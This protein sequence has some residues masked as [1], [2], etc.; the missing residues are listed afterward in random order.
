MY[1]C[2]FERLDNKLTYITLLSYVKICGCG[3]YRI[4]LHINIAYMNN[5]TLPKLAILFGGESSEHEVSLQ[6]A[7]N[8]FNA[9]DTAMFNPVLIGITKEGRWMFHPDYPLNQV[10]LA[11]KNYFDGAIEVMMWNRNGQAEIMTMA[12]AKTLFKVDV[13]F[14]IIHGSFGEDGTL[15]G[16]LR[17][18]KVP[19]VGP[20]ILGTALCMDKDVTKRI[21]KESGIQVADGIVV[22][23][24]DQG[25]LDFDAIV[26]KL[27]LPVFVKPANAGSSVGVSKVT[28]SLSFKKAIEEGFKFDIKILIEEAIIG[29]EVECAILGNEEPQPSIL[30]EIIP[31]VDFYSYE[32]KY[33]SDSGAILKIP[34]DVPEDIA[35]EIRDT[36]VRAFKVTGCEGMARVD[37]FLQEDGNFILNEINT[38][39][40]FTKIS[41]YPQMWGRTGI[42]YSDL[43]SKL[44]KLAFERHE[45]SNKLER[46]ID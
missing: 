30:G 41:M 42:S 19:F 15:Q 43:I 8:I 24:H 14:P 13:V 33:L 46:V 29:K 35:F 4:I 11:E 5:P 37:F 22:Q 28:D 18:F 3:L 39:P 9:V 6:S 36:A 26:E 27:G 40:G 44:V 10:N 32:A 17:G 38:L 21:L 31:T 20:D 23:K 34:A 1:T 25:A 2:K 16:I 7:S 45:R 12:E